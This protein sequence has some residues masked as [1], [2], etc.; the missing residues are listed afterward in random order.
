[1]WKKDC[2]EC[3]RVGNEAL[4]ALVEYRYALDA[5]TL[6]RKSDPTYAERRKKLSEATARVRVAQKRRTSHHDTHGR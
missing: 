5:L 2:E 6:T 1:M 4:A 3:T